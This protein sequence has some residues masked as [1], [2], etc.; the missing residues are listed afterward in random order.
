[1]PAL[2]N[3]KH[4]R[5]CQELADGKPYVEA[6]VAAG[7]KKSKSNAFVLR[8]RPEILERTREIVERERLVERRAEE[9]AVERAAERLSITRERVLEEYARI[10]FADIT[11]AVEWG[12]AMMREDKDGNT[13]F[14]QGIE[15]VASKDLPAH[16]R[17]AISEV[18]STKDGLS[19]KFHPKLPALDALGKTLGIGSDKGNAAANVAATAETLSDRDIARR[20]A[21]LLAKGAAQAKGD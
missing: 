3:P 9:K 18:R 19:I 15:L 17:A 8:N 2:K 12:E 16:V 20:L 7:F 6:Y 14:A 13:V 21:F 1:M 10:A 4:E 5:Y 11:H